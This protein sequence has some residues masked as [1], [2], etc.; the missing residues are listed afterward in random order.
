MSVNPSA[1]EEYEKRHNPIWPELEKVLKDPVSRITR[2]SCTRK[3]ASS[4][5]T[6]KSKARSIGRPLP[7]RTPDAATPFASPLRRAG[8]GGILRGCCGCHAP[9]SC[10]PNRRPSGAGHCVICRPV[11][12]GLAK[13]RRLPLRVCRETLPPNSASL[14]SSRSHCVRS[15]ARTALAVLLTRSLAQKKFGRRSSR[16][17]SL[18]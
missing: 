2:S 11:G 16:L 10:G 8:R 3:L 14:S 4:P 5:A 12:S 18:P 17:A 7:Q 13:T 9:W 1:K 15:L 6:P